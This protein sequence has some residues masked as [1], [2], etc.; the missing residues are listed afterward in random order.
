MS[1]TSKRIDELI[2]DDEKELVY[3]MIESAN[4]DL[5]K[6]D[7]G[8]FTVRDTVNGNED[9]AVDLETASDVI[10]ALSTYVCDNSLDYLANE[11]RGQGIDNIPQTADE[12]REAVTRP[13]LQE[14]ISSH[15][16]EIAE[17]V[18][19]ADPDRMNAKVDLNEI[20]DM[21]KG[22]CEHDEP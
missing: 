2:K 5:V 17:I 14:F 9:Y 18:L 20:A 4:F 7:D 13:D 16:T 12:W 10:G 3:D 6:Q 19:V 22:D 11:A 8:G 15:E 21:F 1:D